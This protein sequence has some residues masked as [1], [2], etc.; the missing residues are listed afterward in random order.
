MPL[1][2]SLINASDPSRVWPT[3]STLAMESSTCR[4]QAAVSFLQ[5]AAHFDIGCDFAFDL[6][7]LFVDMK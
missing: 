2:G 4:A 1:E 3:D 6:G 7:F 5:D